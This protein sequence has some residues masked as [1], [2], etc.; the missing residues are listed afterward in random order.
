MSGS[1]GISNHYLVVQ[2][3][4]L[5]Y[6]YIYLRKIYIYILMYIYIYSRIIYI[7]ILIYIY[8]IFIA[9]KRIHNNG[10]NIGYIIDEIVENPYRPTARIVRGR[11]LAL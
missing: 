9:T 2:V 5:I 8:I 6:I 4:G 10:N 11:M 1:V 7:Y 3:V